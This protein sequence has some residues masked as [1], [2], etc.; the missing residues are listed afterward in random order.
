MSLI[1]CLNDSGIEQ[2]RAW[3]AEC[4]AGSLAPAPKSILDDPASSIRFDVERQIAPPELFVDRLSF[5]QHLNT[6]LPWAQFGSFADH[7]G[8]WTWLALYFAD[9]LCPL[10][11][12]RR[13]VGA[14]D[15]YILSPDYK[16]SYRHLVRTPWLLVG[17][18]GPDARVVLA[19]KM[20][21]HGEAAEQ[22]LSR[23]QLVTNSAFFGTLCRL[24]PP[25]RKL[26]I[27]SA[28]IATTKLPV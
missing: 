3:L 23:Q 4:R 27:E 24:Y 25:L 14:D 17:L 19:G 26:E 5:G 10:A 18:H 12:N 28:S 6:L 1:R 2:F 16:R 20:H 13:N 15:R 7:C 22:L 11:G 9:Q 8:L 21:Q